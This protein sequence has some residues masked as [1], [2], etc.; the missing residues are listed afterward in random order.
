[1]KIGHMLRKPGL[2]RTLEL[3]GLWTVA[4]AMPVLS[5]FGEHPEHF[6][7]AGADRTDVVLL[8]VSIVLLAPLAV[9][10]VVLTVRRLHRDTGE[11]VHAIVLAGLVG[12]F[13]ADAA[14][15]HGGNARALAALAGVALSGFVFLVFPGILAW[16]RML[17]LAAPVAF[18]LFLT[19]PAGGLLRRGAQELDTGPTNDRSVV[20]IVLDELP[21]ATLLGPDGRI[22]AERFPAFGRLA[23]RAT[24]YRDATTVAPFSQDAVP[25]ILSGK[26]PDGPA[27]PTAA[28]HPENLFSLLHRS[29]EMH[30][31]ELMGLC[32]TDC[33]RV[34]RPARLERISG[35]LGDAV[36]VMRRRI[37]E[38]KAR[39]TFEFGPEQGPKEVARFEAFTEDLAGYDGDRSLYF[40]HVLLPH[41]PYQ[42]LPD[43]TRYRAGGILFGRVDHP[44]GDATYA[45]F[46]AAD[47]L[48][49]R[50]LAQTLY[51]DRMLGA[52]LDE[53]DATGLWDDAVVIVT[54]DHGEAFVVGEPRRRVTPGNVLDVARVPL[55]VA[56]PGEPGGRVVD[57][58]VSTI[59]IVPMLADA[60][61]LELPYDADGDRDGTSDRKILGAGYGFVPIPPDAPPPGASDDLSRS[62]YAPRGLEHLVGDVTPRPGRCIGEVRAQVD[63]VDGSPPVYVVGEVTGLGPGPHD[64]AVAVG[65]RIGGATTTFEDEDGYVR[66]GALLDP[67]LVGGADLSVLR[68]Q[69]DGSLV[70]L[71]P[72]TGP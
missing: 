55:F 49:R 71:C 16:P 7:I 61:D 53:L 20:M 25:A 12:L 58:P 23:E 1:M 40:L 9:A 66:F 24:W 56:R 14:S 30:V 45:S 19:S 60:L 11:I 65:D 8:A 64:V 5:S 35:L 13:A 46:S 37:F 69:R 50:H 44:G 4:V 28:D 36:E 26:Y 67:G 10:A 62:P 29:H 27:A 33:G 59:D 34:G 57:T 47:Y 38:T 39:G 32:Q 72:A 43:G 22:D 52:A 63:V 2:Q 6:A 51:V 31:Y 68:V 42:Y 70:T 17:S 41:K 15:A 48:Y 3:I 18:V 21:V 54:A